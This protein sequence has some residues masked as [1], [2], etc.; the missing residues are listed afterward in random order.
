ML[1]REEERLSENLHSSL[2]TDKTSNLKIN[3]VKIGGQQQQIQM[4]IITCLMTG[5][6]SVMSI[7]GIDIYFFI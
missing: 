7:A 6:I 2:V 3:Q 1:R 5:F 4:Q